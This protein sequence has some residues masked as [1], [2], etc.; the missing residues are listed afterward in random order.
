MGGLLALAFAA[1]MIAPVNPCGFA[2]LPAWITHALGDAASSSAPVRLLRALRAGLAL[3][4]GFAGTL[5]LAGVAVSAAA[6]GL[7][8]AAP[9]LG[10]AVGILLVLL[11]GAMLA[12]RSMSLRLP[13][14][15]GRAI[16]R[17]P[18][19]VRM[20]V[21]GVGYAAAS[22]SCTF[23][24]LLAVI[25]QAQAT[26]SFVGLLL[27]FAIYAAGS[28][29]VLLLV[30][31]VAAVAGSV[32]SRRIA[33]LT[34]FVPKVTAAVLIL[35]GVYLAWY[36]FPVVV[37]DAPSAGR[38]DVAAVSATISN[39]L[40]SNTGVIAGLSTTVVLIVLLSGFLHQR[41]RNSGR[42]TEEDCCDPQ[43]THSPGDRP[44]VPTE[45]H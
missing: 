40:Q 28:A 25:A 42:R 27:V 33:A 35:T 23:G 15:P 1:G 19:A 17:L 8:Q 30:A 26:A 6:R 34:R 44:S 24:V 5:A 38:T 41:R 36:W 31:V 2:L 11:G 14:I 43:S 39:W 29:T 21:F 45:R 20:V 12:G 7:I 3:T 18:S 13:G 16:E 4:I 32:L 9:A 37:G 22:L 10:L